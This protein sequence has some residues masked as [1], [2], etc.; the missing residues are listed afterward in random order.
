MMRLTQLF[1]LGLA[2]I[3]FGAQATPIPFQVIGSDLKVEFDNGS[4][5]G[6]Y[7]DNAMAG[8][9]Y[10]AEDEDF[11]FDFGTVEVPLSAGSG[12]GTLTITLATPDAE[13]DVSDGASFSILSFFIGYVD[14]NWGEPQYFDYSYAGADGGLFK[15]DMYDIDSIF[16][17]EFDLV[18]KITNVRSPN[19][20]VVPEPAPITL[21]GIGLIALSLLGLRRSAA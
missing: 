6:G 5:L 8:P 15:L 19:A 16:F 18:G 10:L 7:D 3:A 14:V 1:L 17:G 4:A 11:E 13:G 9:V 12:T 2:A 20:A 21:L